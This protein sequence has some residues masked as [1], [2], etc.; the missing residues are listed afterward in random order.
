MIKNFISIS[1]ST[2]TQRFTC[3]RLHPHIDPSLILVGG[4]FLMVSLN[5]SFQTSLVKR[6]FPKESRFSSS[7]ICRTSLVFRR[8]RLLNEPRSKKEAR[9]LN[10]S[11]LLGRSSSYFIETIFSEAV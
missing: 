10:E 3:E 1:P 11:R 6:V 9:F 5:E 7:L 8:T 4:S 2:S